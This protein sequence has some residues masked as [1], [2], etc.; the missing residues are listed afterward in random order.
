MVEITLVAL[1][2][3]TI[4][5]ATVGKLREPVH[6]RVADA[7]SQPGAFLLFDHLRADQSALRAYGNGQ[8]DWCGVTLYLANQDNGYGGRAAVSTVGGRYAAMPRLFR[9]E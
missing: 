3:P 5:Q 8:T 2:C 4:L 7:S 6:L 9:G 1:E